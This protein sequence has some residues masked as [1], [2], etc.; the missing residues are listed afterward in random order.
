MWTQEYIRYRVNGCDHGT[1]VQRVLAQIAGQAAGGV[2]GAPPDGLI[3][4]PGRADSFL[5]RGTLES[6]YAAMGRGQ[7]PTSVDSEGGVIWT[8]EYLR[9]RVNAC[10]HA[11]ASSKV[12]S[13]ISGGGVPETCF[14][15]P[16]C[17]YTAAPTSQNVPAA[18]GTFT[19][20]VTRVGSACQWSAES[21]GSFVTVTSGAGNDTGTV[22][23][24]VP[25]NTGPSLS[26]QIRVRWLNG[27]TLVDVNQTGSALNVSVLLVDTAQSTQPTSLCQIKTA[28]TSCTLIANATLSA[29]STFAWTVTYNYPNQITHTQTS[30]SNTF[31]FTHSCGGS[32][33]TPAGTD[34]PMNVSVTVTDPNLGAETAIAA[35]TIKLFTC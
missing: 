11:T 12:A 27:S 21:L 18:G 32:S 1:A 22:T 2:C 4:F 6:T 31:T 7:S 29:T 9:Y 19:I 28:S 35:F 16:A 5:F 30:T 20:A 8:Q 15:P 34:E 13:Q 17:S 10:D 3:L 23:Y 24:T 14:V 26:T 25:A 33:S